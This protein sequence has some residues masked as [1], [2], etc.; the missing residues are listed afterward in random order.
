MLT[1]EKRAGAQE[2]WK[3]HEGRL[4]YRAKEAISQAEPPNS[5]KWGLKTEVK[6]VY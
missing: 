2:V 3:R 6:F 5:Q 1:K 4:Y